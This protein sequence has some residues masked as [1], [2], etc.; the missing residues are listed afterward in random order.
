MAWP[1]QTDSFAIPMTSM[2]LPTM[3]SYNSMARLLSADH[4]D[5]IS[6]V[7]SMVQVIVRELAQATVEHGVCMSAL[8]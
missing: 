2:C 5:V 6:S 7:H 8:S 3:L 1:M 4:F